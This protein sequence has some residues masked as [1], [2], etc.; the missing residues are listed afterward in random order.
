MFRLLPAKALN[1]DQSKILSFGKGSRYTDPEGRVVNSVISVILRETT[2]TISLSTGELVSMESEIVRVVSPSAMGISEM[3]RLKIRSSGSD[4]L[5][6][7]DLVDP[8]TCSDLLGI[9][10]HGYT[11]SHLLQEHG[12]CCFLTSCYEQV[13]PCV[14]YM[15][16]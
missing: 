6:K 5:N 2:L 11:L 12:L 9:I 15:L 3:T 4:T 10:H 1:L 7:I 8:Y 16:L 14:Y 13:F